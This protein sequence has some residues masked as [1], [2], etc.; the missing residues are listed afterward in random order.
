MSGLGAAPEARMIR[1][2][3]VA[4]FFVLSALTL[5]GL[6]SRPSHATPARHA[7]F[8][9]EPAASGAECPYLEEREGAAPQ[10]HA[11]Q[12]PPGHPPVPGYGAD[13]GADLPE[14]HPP[15]HQRAERFPPGHPGATGAARARAAVDPA[16]VL[17][18]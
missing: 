8:V 13:E 1:V 11:F 6:A 3:I 12:L 17:D 16:L 18:L 4:A 2:P 10:G 7:W 14:G 15:V 5:A 9:A